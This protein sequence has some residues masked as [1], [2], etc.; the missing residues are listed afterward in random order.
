MTWRPS[1]GYMTKAG[2][3]KWRCWNEELPAGQK[4]YETRDGRRRL[5]NSFEAAQRAAAELNK[6]HTNGAPMFDYAGMM[7]DDQGNRSIFND[8][9][10]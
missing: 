1:S 8:V 3:P 2:K 9:D 7:L 6:K 10:Q 5:F 4:E